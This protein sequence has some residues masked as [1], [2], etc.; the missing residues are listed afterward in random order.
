MATSQIRRITVG[1]V[2][3]LSQHFL[4]SVGGNARFVLLVSCRGNHLLI[5]WSSHIAKNTVISPH[6]LVWEFFGKTQFPHSFERIAVPLANSATALL[7]FSNI[8]STKDETIKLMKNEKKK[9]QKL[10]WK[11]RNKRADIGDRE[12]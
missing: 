3:K 7:L 12:P 6:F 11:A 5:L 8:D 10:L 4:K 1:F 2:I 9:K